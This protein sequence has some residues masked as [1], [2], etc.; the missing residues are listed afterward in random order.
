[1]AHFV[2]LTMA[3]SD[4]QTVYVNLD[5]VTAIDRVNASH[6][7]TRLVIGKDLA[8]GVKETPEEILALARAKA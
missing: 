6:P 3:N 8:H 2:K 4:S 5:T 7:W 1:M